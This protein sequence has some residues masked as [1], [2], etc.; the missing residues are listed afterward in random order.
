MAINVDKVAKTFTCPLGPLSEAIADSLRYYSPDYTKRV[1][2]ACDKAMTGLR[3]VHTDVNKDKTSKIQV[4]SSVWQY[5]EHLSI[6]W[7]FAPDDPR[8]INLDIKLP[9]NQRHIHGSFHI[10]EHKI[11]VDYVRFMQGGPLSGTEEFLVFVDGVLRGRGGV[12]VC[13]P[14]GS[15]RNWPLAI[16]LENQLLLI[17]KIFDGGQD[18][19]N[20]NGV[21]LWKLEAKSG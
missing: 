18:L 10:S 1:E 9:V 12:F 5:V 6:K 13:S 15:H 11:H 3:Q 2:T 21:S 7:E 17:D 8:Y 14:G 4:G 16:R 20:F 19:V